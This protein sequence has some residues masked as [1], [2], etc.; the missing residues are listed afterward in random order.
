MSLFKIPVIQAAENAVNNIKILSSKGICELFK[1]I[2]LM[3]CGFL[4][5][6]VIVK[7]TLAAKSLEWLRLLYY[8]FMFL[9]DI[10]Y[11]HLF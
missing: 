9:K 11:A 8:F 5:I 4:C 6:K 1:C 2:S 3:R 7:C 10:L